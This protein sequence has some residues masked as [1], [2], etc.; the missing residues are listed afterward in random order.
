MDW[1][2]MTSS[3]EKR[4]DGEDMGRIER[5]RFM[6]EDEKFVDSSDDSLEALGKAIA[7]NDGNEVTTPDL[8][9]YEG[10]LKRGGSH[11]RKNGTY[12]EKPRVDRTKDA[13]GEE[14]PVPRGRPPIGAEVR[15]KLNTSIAA[16]T[17]AMLTEY[18]VPLATVLTVSAQRL[19]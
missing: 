2:D 10:N 12:R 4:F 11:G 7:L 9:R 17:Q 3:E 8:M 6:F 13:Y 1:D 19:I 16:C 15:V 5:G 14:I 18:G